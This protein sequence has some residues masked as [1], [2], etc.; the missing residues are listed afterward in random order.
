MNLSPEL[1]QEVEQMASR[2]GLSLEQFV[3]QAVIEKINALK[4]Q[5]TSSADIAMNGSLTGSQLREQDGILVFD[6]ES[7]D[8]VDFDL[9]LEEG[10]G[11]SWKELGL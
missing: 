3:L 5:V 9:L 2:Q 11:R 10:R 6:T 7:L 8:G 4:A 1:Q